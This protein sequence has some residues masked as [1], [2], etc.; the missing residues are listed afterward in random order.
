MEPQSKRS[1]RTVP[2]KIISLILGYTFWYILSSSHTSTAWIN[3]PLCFYNIPEQKSVNAPE[4][5]SVK[6]AGKRS[7][8]RML[9][10]D[11]LAIHIDAE[12]LRDGRNVLAITPETI[13]LPEQIKLV[14]YSPL[15]PIVELVKKS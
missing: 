12:Q 10:L 1:S 7:E 5:L 4:G 11:E 15:N 8:L 13:F 6:I 2:L 9:D 14:H 3:I